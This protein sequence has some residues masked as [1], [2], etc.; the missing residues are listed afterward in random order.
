MMHSHVAKKHN[1]LLNGL[2]AAINNQFSVGRAFSQYRNDPERFIRNVLGET[3]TRDMVELIHAVRDNQVTVAKSGNAVGKTFI[4]ARLAV[5]WL[6]CFEECQVYSCAAPPEGNLRRLLWG[7][8]GN[9]LEKHPGIFDGMEIKTLHVAKSAI[10]FLTGVSIPAS[11]TASQKEARFSGKHSPNLLFIVD[12]ADGVPDE[13][14]KGIESCM[15]GGHAR[16]LAMFNPRAEMGH[17]CRL[18]RQGRA[19]VVS[20]SALNHPNVLSGEDAI[21]GAVTRETVVRRV[22]Q[23]CRPIADSNDGNSFELPVFLQGATAVDQAGRPF[24][25]LIAGW[26][27]IIEPSFS[28]MVLGRYPA[29]GSTQL[30]SREWV[31]LARSRWDIYVVQHGEVPPV[32][33]L[34]TMG[35][36]IGEFGT[37]ANASCF[38][39]G[40]YVERLVVWNGVDTIVTGH[41]ASAEYK[42]RK[43]RFCN[44]DAT[45]VGAGVAP[46][47][48]ENGC[49][50]HA[51]KVASAPTEKTDLGEFKNLRSQLWWACREWLRIDSGAMLPPDE[52][53]LEELATPTYEVTNGK[54]EVM[55][56]T[57]MREL[58][59]RSPDRADS[60]CLTFYQPELLF[61]DLED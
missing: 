8:I 29:H 38:R 40:G 28:Y 27:R 41:R 23:W 45:G 44:V 26:Y 47:M 50:A 36:D 60:L 21:P 32:A 30:I 58:L 49:R 34:A 24:P 42:T 25:P 53:L 39:Y 20:L 14:F 16:L 10:S 56:K 15:S 18:E 5:W 2:M 61:P 9:V 11:G 22:N 43:V 17:L 35:L 57:T 6:L 13:V 3:L 46:H 48:R 52:A 55:R 19:K 1:D 59:K 54:I 37:D 51:V 31:N 7:E 12:E 4:A 33:I